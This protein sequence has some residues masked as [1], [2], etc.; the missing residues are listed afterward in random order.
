[1]MFKELAYRNDLS[2]LKKRVGSGML[3][4]IYWLTTVDAK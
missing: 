3:V 2:S 4:N 1:M